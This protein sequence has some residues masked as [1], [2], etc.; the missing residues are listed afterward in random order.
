MSRNKGLLLIIVGIVIYLF[1]KNDP[2]ISASIEDTQ[3]NLEQIDKNQKEI[4]GLSSNGKTVIIKPTETKIIRVKKNINKTPVVKVSPNNN[5]DTV[6]KVKKK[7]S[8]PIVEE[9]PVEFDE[10]NIVYNSLDEPL[11][12]IVLKNVSNKNIDAIRCQI[13]CYNRFDEKIVNPMTNSN[14]GYITCEA[15]ILPGELGCNMT[16]YS[17][18]WVGNSTKAKITVKK[19]HFED[20]KVWYPKGK[21]QVKTI[22]R[23]MF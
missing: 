15:L 8:S 12:R 5:I 20:G 14:K 18:L 11:L 22:A 2:R 16:R 6:I 19:V 23:T 3:R 17:L 10:A 13:E 7:K 1:A 4:D 21:N 9:A